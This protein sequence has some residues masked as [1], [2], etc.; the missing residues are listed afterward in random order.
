MTIWK[1]LLNEFQA[2]YGMGG[3]GMASR[4]DASGDRMRGAQRNFALDKQGSEWPYEDDDMMNYGVPSGPRGIDRGTRPGTDVSGGPPTPS[5]TYVKT[6]QN[7]AM[8]Q[9]SRIGPFAP[10]DGPALHGSRDAGPVE[11]ED[12]NPVQNTN[13]S[14][15]TV[16]PKLGPN[17]MWGGNGTI[18][19]Q[20]RG[21]AASPMMGNEPEDIW[22]VPE[23]DKMNELKEFFDPSPVDSEEVENPEQTHE[24]DQSDEEVENK[25]DK[26]YGQEDNHDFDGAKE[27]DDDSSEIEF[28]DDETAGLVMLDDEPAGILSMGAEE[29]GGEPEGEEA[30]GDSDDELPGPGP[31]SDSSDFQLT[32]EPEAGELPK[33]SQFMDPQDNLVG[34]AP[35]TMGLPAPGNA[36]GLQG[37]MPSA[38]GLVPPGQSAWDEIALQVG[39]AVINFRKNGGQVSE[40]FGDYLKRGIA[41]AGLMGS[42][43]MGGPAMAADHNYPEPDLASMKKDVDLP[44][45][46]YLDVY[47]G[48]N[49]PNGHQKPI[50]LRQ[51]GTQQK[52]AWDD[53][54][55]PEMW[56]KTVKK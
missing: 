12:N 44:D 35:G 48:E 40:A 39:D 6:W 28:G 1:Q 17:N 42:L 5:A 34:G 53:L 11:D 9:P 2:G 15:F 22:K 24:K 38:K 3:P 30:P 8:G 36:R 56:A 31:A 51:Q 54:Q 19:G 26:I 43:A 49:V 52:S 47:Q 13:D 55:N 32:V 4:P 37:M 45:D 41:G 21:W 23:D 25:T 33:L 20:D 14:D 7:E 27:S 46:Q 18:P 16:D 10:F 29:A 50:D